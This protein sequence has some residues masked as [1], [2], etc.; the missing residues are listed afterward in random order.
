[1][2]QTRGSFSQLHDNTD[3]LI[4]VMLDKQLKRLPNIWKKYTNVESSDRQTEISLGVVGF[5]DVPEKPEGDPYATALLRPGHEKRVTHTEFGYGFEVTKTALEDDRYKQLNKHAMWFMFSA[6]YVQ[7]K[8]AANLRSM[9]RSA[10]PAP[11]MESV[12]RRWAART[13]RLSVAVAASIG[14]PS[15]SPNFTAAVIRARCSA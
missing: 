11:P 2:A 1:M 8:R 7:E 12:A 10:V 14:M 5:D 4:F 15:R 13:A 9:N 3:R 6:G